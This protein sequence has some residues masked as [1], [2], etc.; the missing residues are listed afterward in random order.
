MKGTRAGNIGP[1]NS[2]PMNTATGRA[3]TLP[4][5]RFLWTFNGLNFKPVDRL[6]KIDETVASAILRLTD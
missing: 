2:K 5:F 4:V 6:T 1:L 3:N